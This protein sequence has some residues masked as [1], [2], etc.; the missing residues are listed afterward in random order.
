VNRLLQFRKVLK[1][2]LEKIIITLEKIIIFLKEYLKFKFITGG[3][4]KVDSKEKKAIFKI[5]F[6]FFIII[7]HLFTC[8]YI[9]WVISL[10]CP[11]P[12]PLTLL[13]SRQN[14]FCTF[15]QFR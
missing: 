14:L 13:P 10:P 3:G 11:L 8:A 12:H 5:K 7:I 4:D 9:V 6:Y 2:T 15:L 1:I